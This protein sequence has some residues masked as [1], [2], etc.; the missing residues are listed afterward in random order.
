MFVSFMDVC[1]KMVQQLY[2]ASIFTSTSLTTVSMHT[3]V[4]ANDHYSY[5]SYGNRVDANGCYTLTGTINISSVSLCSKNSLV[6]IPFYR[7]CVVYRLHIVLERGCLNHG[8]Y[9]QALVSLNIV[10]A[11]T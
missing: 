7:L 9:D 3:S 2:T 5:C 10:I 1:K 8:V 11:Y 6:Y 4:L